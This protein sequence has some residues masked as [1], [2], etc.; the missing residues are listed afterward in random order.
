MKRIIAAVL[1]ALLLLGAGP[2][3]HAEEEGAPV[4]IADRADLLRIAEDP[5][6]TYELTDDIDMGG[7][8]W[9]P[10][11]F[12]GKL[13]GHG[14]TLYNLTV[15]APGPDST[16]TYDGNRKE[17]DTVFGG[18]FSVV[19]DAH[20]REVNLVNAV[21]D[22]TTDQHCFLG[23]VAGYAEHSVIEN[24][25]V[26]T[27][28]HLTLT[29]INA[30]LGGLC[31]FSWESEFLGCTVDA[32]L[33][34]TDTNKD[35][36]CEEFIGGV[37]SCGSGKIENC[38]V[39]TRGFSEVYGYCHNGGLVGMFKA[40]RDS[41]YQSRIYNT[42]I[43][44]ELSFFEITPSRRAYCLPK[45]GEDTLRACR[46]DR[47]YILNFKKTESRTP[48]PLSPEKCEAPQYADAV[49]PGDCTHWG[50]T[51]HTC[52]TCGYSYADSYTPPVH[53]YGAA[54][55][56][57][58]PT[59]TEQG[60]QT[61]TCTLCG[62]S[63]AEPVPATG[64]DYQETDTA[65]TCTVNGEKVFACANCGDRYTEVIP[66]LGHTPGD[67]T[68]AKAAQVNVPGEEQKVCETCG[69]VLERRDIPALPYIYAERLTLS[70]EALAL[71]VGD[72][73]RLT[74]AI[75]PEDATDPTWTFTSSDP[76]VA[77]VSPDGTIAAHAPGTAAVIAI[78]TD[79]RATAACIV[80][81]TYTPWQWV[82]HYILFGWAW[83]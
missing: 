37:Y 38:T 64:H 33:I 14:H 78:S 48:V 13:D 4:A 25:T 83:E 60:E 35:A 61:Y 80:T 62:H 81:V 42:T 71:H 29:S 2:A 79:G 63:Y 19:K 9:V 44:A 47:V 21:I 36:L 39:K 67:W 55:L 82:K 66:A 16:M 7:E 54:E 17:Y 72:A 27:R 8:A 57:T 40:V 49:T 52:S 58:K 59:C 23:A 22:V 45:I 68:V 6:G 11:A 24:C 74:A 70:A 75:A 1:C 65:P 10:L 46:M 3:V 50:Y 41:R 18:L 77:E 73:A 34:F 15:T 43:D 26:Q 56:T 76:A 32:E 30:G 28:S 31:G 12:S 51:T 5:T 69:E 20:I 53:Q